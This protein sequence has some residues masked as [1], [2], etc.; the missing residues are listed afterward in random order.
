RP[1]HN[2]S[3]ARRPIAPLPD[4]LVSQ[5][6][7][8]E[9]VERPAS[10]VKELLENAIDAGAGRI[11]LRIEEGGIRRVVVADDGVGIP[12]EEL[13]LAL[14][15]HAT[16]KIGSLAEL[17]EVASLGFRGEAL[18][19]IA[20]VASVTITS[21]TAGADSA[22]RIDARD[23]T[24]A[25]AAGTRGTV[26]EVADLYAQTPARRKFLRSAAT[27]AAHCVE[28]FRRVAIAH[29]GIGFALVVD[30]RRSEQ[31]PAGGWQ[32]RALAGLGAD[33][34]D[35]HPVLGRGD[36]A[37]GLH[38]LLGLPTGSRA[39]ADRQYFHVNGR[40]VRDRVLMHAVRQAYADV[41]HGERHP[42]YVLALALDPKL[43]DVNVHPAKTEVRFRDS[44]A[45]HRLVFNAVRDALRTGAG[46]APA[47][48]LL[49]TA[50]GQGPGAGPAV[51][52]RPPQS[53]EGLGL[54]V[55]APGVRAAALANAPMG[56][57]AS[58]PSA[59]RAP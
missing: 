49:A 34:R 40:F 3:A 27:E 46:A 6:A 50:P 36:E 8:G 57:P 9:V 15:R 2:A 24:V 22:W 39:R 11:E 58:G 45:V 20:S 21:R 7:A 14:T 16:S 26:V 31:W 53:Q 41:L 10:V 56:W 25:Q 52:F 42:A 51:R 4:M 13:P 28:A 59:G 29:P 54:E 38:G 47:P 17:E 55:P 48:G 44:Q 30:G 35:A 12:P 43:V 23:G 37:H 5:I 18:A 19:S 1:M 32:A 33:L